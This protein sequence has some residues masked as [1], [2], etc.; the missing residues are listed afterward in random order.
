MYKYKNNDRKKIN[1]IDIDESTELFESFLKFN[2]TFDFNS[3]LEY[4]INLL[5]NENNHHKISISFD[6]NN[7]IINIKMIMYHMILT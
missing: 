7:L 5:D 6:I 4:T 3:N 1:S 2:Y